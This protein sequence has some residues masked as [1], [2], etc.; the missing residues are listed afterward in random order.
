MDYDLWSGQLLIFL[1]IHSRAS[2]R[3]YTTNNGMHSLWLVMQQI[4]WKGTWPNAPFPLQ[5]KGCK[6]KVDPC[7][8]PLSVSAATK[9]ITYL[10]HT[11]K[12]I[13]KKL[14]LK[15]LLIRHTIR[16]LL[17]TEHCLCPPSPWNNL[18]RWKAKPSSPLLSRNVY[19]QKGKQ[20]FAISYMFIFIYENIFHIFSKLGR[21]YYSNGKV[22]TPPTLSQV[23]RLNNSD[24]S[25]FKIIHT[26]RALSNKFQKI[27]K[28]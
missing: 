25:R 6:V 3:S 16:T 4:T 11:Q 22:L 8:A 5:S 15:Y 17:G 23:S 2:Q 14:F 26:G 24:L 10:S 28:L 18:S 7:L 13:S 9:C 20:P 12:D 1:T 19:K 27:W 21:L